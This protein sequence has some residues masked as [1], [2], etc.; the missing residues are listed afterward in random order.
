MNLFSGLFSSV[1]VH[2]PFARQVNRVEVSLKDLLQ[3]PA[4]VHVHSFLED[5]SVD[6]QAPE[7]SEIF[8]VP[9]ARYMVTLSIAPKWQVHD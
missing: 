1:C 3:L 7:S 9:F 2:S 8:Q 5:F 6:L 4:P